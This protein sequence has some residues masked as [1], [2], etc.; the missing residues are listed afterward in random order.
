MWPKICEQLRWHY[1][2]SVGFDSFSLAELIHLRESKV[3]ACES[4]RGLLAAKL[5]NVRAKV[6]HLRKLESELETDL[7]KCSRE[8]K[9]RRLHQACPCPVLE[10]ATGAER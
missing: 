9:H 10:D 1:F 3:E 6:R 4:V 8:L 5:A 2:E 7:C